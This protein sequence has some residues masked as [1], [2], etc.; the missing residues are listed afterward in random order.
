[1][2]ETMRFLDQIKH[3]SLLAGTRLLYQETCVARVLFDI[4]LG[5]C[6]STTTTRNRYEDSNSV[7]IRVTGYDY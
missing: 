4:E 6:N 2:K 1:M 3:L 5:D 7:N